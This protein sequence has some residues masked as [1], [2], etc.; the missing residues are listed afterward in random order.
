[1]TVFVKSSE[2]IKFKELIVSCLNSTV[3]MRVWLT[4]LYMMGAWM[5]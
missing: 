2:K 1:M 5:T 3:G 4:L